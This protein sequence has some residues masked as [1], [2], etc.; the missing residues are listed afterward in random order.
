MTDIENSSCSSAIEIPSAVRIN[1]LVHTE[2]E[3][4]LT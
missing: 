1:K 4:K 2:D 3:M